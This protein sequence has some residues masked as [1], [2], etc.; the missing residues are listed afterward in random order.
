MISSRTMRKEKKEQSFPG[1]EARWGQR[2]W[3]QDEDALR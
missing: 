2:W 3:G 1:N